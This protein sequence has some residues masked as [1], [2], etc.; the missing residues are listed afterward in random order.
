MAQVLRWFF[1]PAEFVFQRFTCQVPLRQLI[2]F[3]SVS[4]KIPTI[5]P[6]RKTDN[7]EAMKLSEHEIWLVDQAA[8]RLQEEL[9]ETIRTEHRKPWF[10]VFRVAMLRLAMQLK[11]KTK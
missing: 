10:V 3:H 5:Q 6:S 11:R 1:G 9:M 7:L 8:A 4:V 2:V